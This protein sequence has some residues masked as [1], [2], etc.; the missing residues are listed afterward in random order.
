[1]TESIAY[2]FQNGTLFKE[3]STARDCVFYGE[4][5]A[6]ISEHGVLFKEVPPNPMFELTPLYKQRGVSDAEIEDLASFIF[7]EDRAY[8]YCDVYK[9]ARALLQ[10]AR[11]K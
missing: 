8:E 6:Y 2:R 7:T 3:P 11:E 1:M 9:F 10:K 4:P 5:L